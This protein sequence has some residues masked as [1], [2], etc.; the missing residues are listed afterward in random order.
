MHGPDVR[1]HPYYEYQVIRLGRFKTRLEAE[2]LM[3]R[4]KDNYPEISVVAF[5]P[6][7]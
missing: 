4:F 2:V 1:M 3:N 5:K 6:K 7:R